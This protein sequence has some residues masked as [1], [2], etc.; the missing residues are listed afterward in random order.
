MAKRARNISIRAPGAVAFSAP[1]REAWRCG[2][3]T[4]SSARN[5]TWATRNNARTPARAR[6]RAPLPPHRQGSEASDDILTLQ[7]APVTSTWPC[8]P[9]SCDAGT[10]AFIAGAVAAVGSSVVKVPIAV[11]IR[12]VQ[13]GVYPN[14]FAAARS[15]VD[16]AGPRGLFTVSRAAPRR[17]LGCER[18]GAAGTFG[19]VRQGVAAM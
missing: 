7:T 9:D 17:D 18:R 8:L 1:G 12:S 2:C 3:A 4:R 11:C 19:A 6:V 15:V 14:V 16:R 5:P 13:A 10:V